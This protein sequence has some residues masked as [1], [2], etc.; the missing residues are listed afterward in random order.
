MLKQFKFKK[1]KFLNVNRKKKTTEVVYLFGERV[2]S[3]IG[4][5]IIS[6]LAVIGFFI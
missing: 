3:S 2:S 1:L 4:R 6:G 5:T